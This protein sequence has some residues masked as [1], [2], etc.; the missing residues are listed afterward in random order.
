[1]MEIEK[2]L[3]KYYSNNYFWQELSVDQKLV[4]KVWLETGFCIVSKYLPT[5]YLLIPNDGETGRYHLNHIKKLKSSIMRHV[6][7]M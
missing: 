1:M 4:G 3:S 7:L 2:S 6:V 5:R